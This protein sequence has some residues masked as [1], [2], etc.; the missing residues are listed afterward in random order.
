MQLQYAYV[1]YFYRLLNKFMIGSSSKFILSFEIDD[2]YCHTISPFCHYG[3]MDYV[4][5]YTNTIQIYIY[6][7]N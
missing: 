2:L 7:T 4:H 3:W 1:T 5:L 6:L